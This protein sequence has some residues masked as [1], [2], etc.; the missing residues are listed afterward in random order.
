MSHAA[1]M[2]GTGFSPPS[3]EPLQL[4]TFEVGG[5]E[6]GIDIQAVHEIDRMLPI[7]RVPQSP[8]EVEGVAN[9]RGR[10]VPVTD[11]RRR[12]GLE[13]RERDEHNRIVVVEAGPRVAGL[14]VE[15]VHEVLRIPAESVDP[16]PP[17]ACPIDAE[18]IA[19]VG[20][21]EDRTVILLDASKFFRD[22]QSAAADTTT[23]RAA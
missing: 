18:F 10:I 12:F 6:F 4:V 21:L 22:D 23:A 11:L 16:A 8:S 13:P 5:E 9:L 3:R 2:P 19:G 17:T 14:I 15:R 1:H 20:R 7:S